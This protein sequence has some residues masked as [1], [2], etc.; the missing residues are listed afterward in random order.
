[1]VIEHSDPERYTQAPKKG[2]LVLELRAL[3]ARRWVFEVF[4][5][6]SCN[7]GCCGLR[8]FRNSGLGF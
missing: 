8:G 1:M 4:R 7:L 5:V 3:H 2:I 6:L